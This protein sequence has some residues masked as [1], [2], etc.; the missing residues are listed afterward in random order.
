LREGNLGE[1]FASPA[2]DLKGF[3]VGELEANHIIPLTLGEE[4]DALGR[5]GPSAYIV[6]GIHMFKL[7][8]FTLFLRLLTTRFLTV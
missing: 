6:N 5:D 8:N 4:E 7:V 1:V 2:A 3:A